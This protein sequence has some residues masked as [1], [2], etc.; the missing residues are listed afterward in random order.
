VPWLLL[1][2]CSPP[3]WIRVTSRVGQ[4]PLSRSG[5]VVDWPEWL[6]TKAVWR[7]HLERHFRLRD[8]YFP[9]RRVHRPAR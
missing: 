3:V 1:T 7:H 2:V 5:P 9:S 8:L 4:R 6:Q